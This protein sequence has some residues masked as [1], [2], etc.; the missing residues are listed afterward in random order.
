M[1]ESHPTYKRI[2]MHKQ[3]TRTPRKMIPEREHQMAE[4]MAK[5]PDER[6]TVK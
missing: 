6:N 4:I 1:F 3:V 2:K 5:R